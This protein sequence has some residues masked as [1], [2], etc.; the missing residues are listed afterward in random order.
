MICCT[1]V[2]SVIASPS[3]LNFLGVACIDFRTYSFVVMGFGLVPAV[4]MMN[5]LPGVASLDARL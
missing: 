2:I 3:V 5:A 4:T 1:V